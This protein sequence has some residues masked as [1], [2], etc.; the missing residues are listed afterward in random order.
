MHADHM[1]AT[2]SKFLQLHRVLSFFVTSDLIVF[3]ISF[4]LQRTMLIWTYEI[5]AVCFVF[6][7]IKTEMFGYWT[8][9][10]WPSIITVA[11]IWSH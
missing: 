6:C 1:E 2:V 9:W 10:K 4:R 5:V 3:N 7:N 8:C 11:F